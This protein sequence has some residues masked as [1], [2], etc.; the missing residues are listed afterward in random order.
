MLILIVS[1]LTIG[2][3]LGLLGAGGSAMTVPVLV[4][5]MGHSVK[6]SIAES[7]AIV[8]LVSFFAALPYAITNNIDWRIAWCFGIPGT[9]GTLIGAWLGGMSAEETQLVVLGGV[10]LLAALMMI[11]EVNCEDASSEVAS[12]ERLPIWRIA[13]YGSIVG[14]VTGFVGVGG[15]FLIVPALVVLSKLPMR[16]AIGTSLV[17]ISVN[18]AVGF[19]KYEHYLRMYDSSANRQ[20][21]QVFVL[22]GIVGTQFGRRINAKLDQKRLRQVF[23]GFLILLGSYVICRE[24]GGLFSLDQGEEIACTKHEDRYNNNVFGRRCSFSLSDGGC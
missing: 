7:M 10:L 12:T 6:E 13:F 20:T 23:A 5:V 21:I 3:T 15:G 18:A 24:A 22:L 11:R 4:Y 1:A 8:G 2:L 14:M 17:I 19:A 9:V 16:L